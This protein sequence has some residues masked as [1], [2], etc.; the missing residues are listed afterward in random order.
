MSLIKT[1][2]SKLWLKKNPKFN[3]DYVSLSADG[4]EYLVK[5]GIQ[6]IGVDALSVASFEELVPTHEIL[7]KSKVVIIEGLNLAEIHPGNYILCCL[8]LKIAHSDG[9]PAR[10]VLI[11]NF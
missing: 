1:K 3:T 2:N 6:L 10:A 5:R 7:L 8:P 11:K 9:A 4:A